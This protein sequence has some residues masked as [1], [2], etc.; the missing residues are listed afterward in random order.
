MGSRSCPPVPGGFM[1]ALGPS[2]LYY[3]LCAVQVVPFPPPNPVLTVDVDRMR[4]MG[5]GGRGP[6]L[7]YWWAPQ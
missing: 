7:S 6:S 1:Y 3:F 5:K 2:R 4:R